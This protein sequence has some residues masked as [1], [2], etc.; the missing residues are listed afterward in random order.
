MGIVLDGSHFLCYNI[1]IDDE[2]EK[3]T[4]LYDAIPDYD[5]A[6]IYQYIV[7]YGKCRPINLEKTLSAWAKNKR[8]LYKALGNRLRVEVPYS[9]KM[10]LDYFAKKARE[11]FWWY[12]RPHLYSANPSAPGVITTADYRYTSGDFYRD[13]L[14]WMYYYGVH[15]NVDQKDL[16]EFFDLSFN[17]NTLFEG[18]YRLCGKDIIIKDRAGIKDIKIPAGTK[19][20]KAVRK[21]LTAYDYPH[22]ELFEQWRDEVS[23]LLSH[24]I[25]Q[26]T[27]VLSIHPIDFMSMSDTDSWS[28]CMS[29]TKNGM[30][31]G[32]TIE[33][34]NSNVALV[35]YVKGSG[36][37][38]TKSG[39]K[40]DVKNWR[41]LFYAHKDI[42]LSGCAYPFE[43]SCLSSFITKELYRLV[44]KNLHWDY[45]YKGQDYMDMLNH[46]TNQSCRCKDL[47]KN[48]KKNIFVTTY[49]MYNDIV[50][51]RADEAEYICY[52]NPVKKAKRISL[53][54][55][56]TCL[57]CGERLDDTPTSAD[58]CRFRSHGEMKF[59]NK[60][61]A[62]SEHD[63]YH[64]GNH[65]EKEDS[66]F[67]KLT[68]INGAKVG[69]YTC[70]DCLLEEDLIYDSSNNLS[71]FCAS[72]KKH[73]G[74][75]LTKEMIYDLAD[76]P[77]I[78]SIN[79]G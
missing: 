73:D 12:R 41:S 32:G 35:A 6:A 61:Y 62:R 59:C 14:G 13:I 5:K 47:K 58:D 17:Y 72:D 60:H 54:G 31:N 68:L 56:A 10:D 50:E 2:E 38:V 76:N 64:C 4:S 67:V 8:T 1:I 51:K 7:D 22:M 24:K 19:V 40:M 74:V 39:F 44:R 70:I 36:E 46:A 11:K 48:K 71:L 52:R 29:W 79:R 9:Y 25:I 78:G 53:S 43:D 30:F 21:V 45:K 75:S 63:C 3:L 49:G 15:K 23:V 20:M 57:I 28:T 16:L 34:M 77:N 66:F 27:V 37:F 55:Y 18:T 33:M 69:Y 65:L 26:K 42:L